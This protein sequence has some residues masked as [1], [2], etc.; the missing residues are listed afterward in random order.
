MTTD[1][2]TIYT[3]ASVPLFFIAIAVTGL[4]M[5]AAM[6][7]AASALRRRKAALI[8]TITATVGLAVGAIAGGIVSSQHAVKDAPEAWAVNAKVLQA[9]A[10]PAYGITIDDTE[11]ARVM[12]NWANWHSGYQVMPLEPS[13]QATGADGEMTLTLEEQKDGSFRLIQTAQ[14]LEPVGDTK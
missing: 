5:L 1:D 3:D 10:E 6:L 7:L 8:L 14:V 12:A 9:W 4:G 11:A 13:F 2:L